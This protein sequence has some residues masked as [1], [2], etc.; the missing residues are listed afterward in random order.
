MNFEPKP[1]RNY[2]KEFKADA[3]RLALN[4]DRTHKSVAD[5]LGITPKIL[6]KWIRKVREKGKDAFP[7]KGNLTPED[8][9]MF[10]LKRENSIL[11]EERDI[12]KKALAVFSKEN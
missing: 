3:V 1:R 10:R 6:E 11:K 9:E 2:D 5:S 4:G 8:E 7:G 12:L